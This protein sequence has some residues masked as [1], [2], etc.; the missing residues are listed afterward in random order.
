MSKDITVELQFFLIS[1]LWGALILILYDI[2]RILRRVIKHNYFFIAIEDLL[3]WVISSLFIFAMIYNENNGIIRGFSIMGMALGMV[4]YHFLLSK[5]VVK[6]ISELIK[7]ILRPFRFVDN[8]LKKFSRFLVSKI[9][10][11]LKILSMRLKKI[12]KSVKIAINEKRIKKLNKRK[13]VK[14][15]KEAKSKNKKEA[16]SKNKKEAKSI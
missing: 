10:K 16:K 15:K 5:F 3:F 11:F 2:L 9:R 12:A 8:S 4:I 1:I 14:E 6:L 13:I 7:L